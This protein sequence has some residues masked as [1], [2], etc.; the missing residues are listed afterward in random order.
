M[1]GDYAIEWPI[2]RSL[3][4]SKRHEEPSKSHQK[5]IEEGQGAKGGILDGEHLKKRPT[6]TEY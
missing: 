3:G 1:P 2:Q 6:A 5:A 4:P